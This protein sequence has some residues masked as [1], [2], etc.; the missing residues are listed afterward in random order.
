MAHNGLGL[1]KTDQHLTAGFGTG[2]RLSSLHLPVLTG[3]GFGVRGNYK[4]VWRRVP[5]PDSH[6]IRLSER[7]LIV[8]PAFEGV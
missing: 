8:G 5:F 3:G 2:I 7:E 6:A 4:V 1:E